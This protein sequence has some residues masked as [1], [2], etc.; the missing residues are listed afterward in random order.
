MTYKEISD[1]KIKRKYRQTG[2]LTI[3]APR[4]SH[5]PPK[6]KHFINKQ[7]TTS[8]DCTS[9]D[10]EFNFLSGAD[11]FY[12][13]NPTPPTST[14]SYMEE[15]HVQEN[16]KSY[17]SQAH[18]LTF[19]QYSL[20]EIDKTN[21]ND[22]AVLNCEISTTSTTPQMMID[23]PSPIPKDFDNDNLNYLIMDTPLVDTEL[24]TIFPIHNEKSFKQQE[25]NETEIQEVT[26]SIIRQLR[27]HCQ[28]RKYDVFKAN[29]AAIDST[30]V[31]ERALSRV[32]WGDKDS[33]VFFRDDPPTL[34]WKTDVHQNIGAPILHEAPPYSEHTGEL[35]EHLEC[36]S[37]KIN[38]NSS[39]SLTVAIENA[40]SFLGDRQ[41][42]LYD[43][44]NDLFEAAHEHV[45]ISVGNFIELL[46]MVIDGVKTLNSITHRMLACQNRYSEI[47]VG[48]AKTIPTEGASWVFIEKELLLCMVDDDNIRNELLANRE[49]FRDSA[50]FLLNHLRSTLT[51]VINAMIINDRLEDLYLKFIC[52]M[53]D[54]L[55]DGQLS[56]LCYSSYMSHIEFIVNN[57]ETF[58]AF[59]F[60]SM[61]ENLISNHAKLEKLCNT[62]LESSQELYH[63]FKARLMTT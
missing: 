36:L 40:N 22:N 5:S 30:S 55:E 11:E 23:L 50:S 2:G 32:S 17:S 51:E 59:D 35:S 45:K 26:K 13:Q 16:W 62:M 52:D 34:I 21:T 27:C 61:M 14:S 1:E 31:T 10:F 44:M 49:F 53:G 41:K 46:G 7:P 63:H 18:D 42:V 60:E 37:P 20:I 38:F 4:N 12:F 54:S 15:L 47:E 28:V 39:Q 57:A 43:E 56:F 29:L 9:S 3:K 33:Q 24:C 25:D 48:A 6:S 58:S 8:I 19:N